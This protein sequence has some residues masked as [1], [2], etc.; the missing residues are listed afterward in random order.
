MN[1]KSKP[2]A[3]LRRKAEEADE[4][5][6]TFGE[7]TVDLGCRLVTV[8]GEKLKLTLVE[9]EILKCLGVHRGRM[10]THTHLLHTIR[11]PHRS[12]DTHYL[13][14]YVGQLRRKIE[15]DPNH[16]RYIITEPGVGFKLTA[17]G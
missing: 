15:E 17:T 11:G 1:W 9:Y 7:L 12:V 16:P 6:L 13:R 14:V 10:V 8:P 3:A 5:I 2:R 4:P